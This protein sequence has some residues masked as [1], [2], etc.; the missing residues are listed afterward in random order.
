M[1]SAGVECDQALQLLAKQ[2]ADAKDL[3]YQV[4]RDIYYIIYAIKRAPS[5]FILLLGASLAVGL[6]D[7]AA[8]LPPP[9]L[10][11]P[12]TDDS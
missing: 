5:L 3:L 11:M 12:P 2:A 10:A 1:K 6:V 8:P 7:A 4:R 9:R